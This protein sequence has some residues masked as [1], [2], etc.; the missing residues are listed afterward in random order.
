[1]FGSVRKLGLPFIIAWVSVA[2]AFGP[3][4]EVQGPSRPDSPALAVTEPTQ[5]ASLSVTRGLCS[6]HGTLAVAILETNQIVIAIDSRMT[7][8]ERGKNNR[9]Q[10][11]MEK[12]VGL[13][14]HVAFFVTGT[15]ALSNRRETNSLLVIAKA[16]A[17][18]WQKENRK[19]QLEEL[20]NEFKARASNALSRLTMGDIN[21]LHLDSLKQGGTN[22]FTAAFAGQDT[23]ATLKLFRVICSTAV[24]TNRG[25]IDARL[26]FEVREEK[27]RG[28]QWFL[29]LGSS[30]AFE[31]GMTD[32]KSPLAPAIRQ[33]RSS[34]ALLAEPIAAALVDV[35]IRHYGDEP[36]SPVGYP[37]FVYTLDADGFRLTRKVNKGEGVPFDKSKQGK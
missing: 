10:D 21:A 1:M 19:L 33:I 9:V 34:R 20:A 22:L 24:E 27:R 29:F 17:A 18:E 16:L 5:A 31:R 35:G 2:G 3:T 15:V 28:K 26:T 25:Y 7:T 11:G 13:S 4:G 6:Q 32:P 23:D 37:I 36:E 12:V 14:S 30:G 8:K